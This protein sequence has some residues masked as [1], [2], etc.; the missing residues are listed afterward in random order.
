MKAKFRG[1]IGKLLNKKDGGFD[2]NTS[3]IF[4]T[5]DNF[6]E[7]TVMSFKNIERKEVKLENG[8]TY[9]YD[10]IQIVDH[11]LKVSRFRFSADANRVIKIVNEAISSRCLHFQ[12]QEFNIA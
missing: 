6:G 10:Y 8:K 12:E 11:N 7:L 4:G 9:S 2:M 1:I 5:D 3:L